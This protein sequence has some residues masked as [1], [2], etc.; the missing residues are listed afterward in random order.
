M[1]VL[2]GIQPTGSLHIG[3]YLGAIKQWIALQEKDDTECLFFIA[4]LHALTVPYEPSDLKR[5]V[6]EVAAAYVAAGVDPDKSI[7]FVQSDVKEHTELCWLLNTVTPVGDLQRMTE[8]KD[9]A[10]RFKKN[11]NAGLLDYPVLMAADI[12]LYKTHVVP[13]GKDQQQHLELSRTI[14][15]KFNQRFGNIFVEPKAFIPKT[16]ARVMA[17]GNPK[18]KMSKSLGPQNYISLFDEPKEIQK[19]VMTAVTDTGKGISYS[20]SKK[21]GISNLLTIY[22]LLSS[23][24]IKELEVHFKG[25]GYKDLKVSLVELLTNELAPFRKKKKELLS[26]E[27]FVRE[28]LKKGSRRAGQVAQGTMQE[29]RT[30]MGLQA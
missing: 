11:V 8:Y 25:K 2:S 16:G 3:N 9:K 18:K 4:D 24:P 23:T 30:A 21:P 14:A 28:M 6:L 19:K 12:L 15:R 17:L 20:V 7:F 27:V 22:S 29:V 5:A 13:V 1:R 26:R 10:K